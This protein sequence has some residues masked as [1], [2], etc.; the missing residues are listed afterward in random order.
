MAS[1]DEWIT[2]RDAADRLGVTSARIRQMVSDGEIT[3][4]K[5]GGKYRGQWQVSAKEIEKRVHMKGVTGT[6]RVKNRMTPNPVTATLKTSYNQALRLMQQNK[7][8][9]LPILDSHGNLVGIVTQSD[10]LRAEPSP[11]TTLSVYEMAS[12]LE[13]VTMDKIMSK[14]VLAIDESCTITEAANYMVIND[15]GCLP[16]MRDG[17]LA[18]IITDS[19]IFKTF[20][21]ITGGGQAGTRI[22]ARMPDQK[23]Q[24]AP[25]I[26]AFTKADSY[27]VSVAISYDK[28]GEHAFVD[29]KER[30]GDENKIMEELN[31]LKNVEVIEF[32]TSEKDKLYRFG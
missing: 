16:V 23:G 9:S 32:R 3:G 24:L 12:L 30:G 22:E 6:M 18:G 4:K 28:D 11:V 5:I 1:R 29:I 25:F 20:I 14:P 17:K 26:E 8:K 27:I 19:D 15:L 2:T 10:M 13:K 31:K 7:I 21:D